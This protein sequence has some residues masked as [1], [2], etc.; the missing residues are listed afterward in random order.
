MPFIK[1]PS[2][3]SFKDV[4]K[5][6]MR[7]HVETLTFRGKIKLHG[8]KAAIRIDADGITAE[9]RT[10]DVFPD[11][12]NA[13]FARFVQDECAARIAH[14][15]PNI[16]MTIH[17]E[18]AGPGIQRSDAITDTDRKR[19]FVFAIEFHADDY[20]MLDPGVITQQLTAIGLLP[21]SAINVLPWATEATTINILNQPECQAFITKQVMYVD[22]VIGVED[23][24]VK[25]MFGVSGHGEGLVFYNV[26]ALTR[27][28]RE[29]L[30]KV[31][32]EAH[33][34]N[35]DKQRDRVAPAKPEGMDE[36]VEMF[37]TEQRFEQMLNEHLDGVADKTKF[38]D[39]IGAVMRD[40][41]KESTNELELADFAWKDV[42]K[43]GIN[44]VKLW[45][46]T[47]C[48]AI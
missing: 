4:Y 5:H 22:G 3:E 17:G 31:K 45:F 47:K 25:E 46:F 19:F 8:T 43:Y 21:H 12:D 41:Q 48:D 36:F 27:S 28:W 44:T 37:F 32:S 10:S 34:V 39:F 29:W 6:A 40:V 42:A 35:K 11:A 33:S 13:G 16:G 15:L 24:Y 14:Y 30:F 38:G 9:K 7:N 18:W 1:W 23:P 20:L 26:S 2:I